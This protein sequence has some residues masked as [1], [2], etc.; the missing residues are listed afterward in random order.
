MHL[1]FKRRRHQQS[2]AAEISRNGARTAEIRSR[3]RSVGERSKKTTADSDEIK[4]KTLRK[5]HDENSLD[6]GPA[7]KGPGGSSGAVLDANVTGRPSFRVAGGGLNGMQTRRRSLTAVSA[8][9]SSFR[10]ST[11]LPGGVEAASPAPNDAPNPTTMRS[12][13]TRR[14]S[15]FGSGTTKGVR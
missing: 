8:A 4:K 13:N 10:S 15:L 2:D 11:T 3:R 12:P 7:P 5:T 14:R 6:V 9:L 1:A